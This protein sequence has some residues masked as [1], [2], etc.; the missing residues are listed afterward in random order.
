MR[1]T[2]LQ[3]LCFSFLTASLGLG[4][5]G[6][7]REY[8]LPSPTAQKYVVILGGAAAGKKYATRFR[9][10]TLRLYDTLTTDYGYQPEQIILLLGH[11]D[12][13]EPRISGPCRRET[14]QDTVR[15]LKKALRPGDQ[16]FFFLVGHGTSDEEE[17]KFVIVGPDITHRAFASI[18]EALLE[19]DIVVVNTTSSSYPFCAALSGPGRVIICS[20]RASAERYDTIFPQYFIE[21]LEDHAGDRD[22]NKRVSMWEAFLF[23]HRSV[24]KW[25]TERDRLS[26][27]HAVLDD[28]GD[29]LFSN[30]PDPAKNDGRL[31]QVAY[32]DLLPSEPTLGISAGIN[33]SLV[34]ELA[35]KMRDL[36]RSIFL[37]R[38]RKAELPKRIY[39]KELEDLL[40]EL[41]R[42]NR[43]LKNIRTTPTDSPE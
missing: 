17:A 34:R 39:Q 14:I 6:L 35:A 32:L 36:E 41:A 29:G 27:E 23:V 24:E 4:E 15:D 38:N 16:V 9:E 20:T 5:T 10:W 11:G 19:Q 13:D 31:A 18:L 37:L 3:L 40:I 42:T 7:K 28:N 21:A 33:I 12:P 25:Y 30:N 43:E 26:S 2:L 1:I 8:F 22:K